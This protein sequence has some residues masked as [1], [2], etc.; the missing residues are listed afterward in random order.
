MTGIDIIGEG[1]GNGG[2]HLAAIMIW[3]QTE[4]DAKQRQ[5]FIVRACNSHDALVAVKLAAE[6]LLSTNTRGKVFQ[7]Y[8]E[9]LRERVE[10][11]KL[12]EGRE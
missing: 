1:I 12:A 9:T 5:A 3:G 6:H 10:S 7:F 4:V 2:D 8:L 11:L